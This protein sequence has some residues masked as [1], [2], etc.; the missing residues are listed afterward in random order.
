[1]IVIIAEAKKEIAQL[2]A[3]LNAVQELPKTADLDKLNAN[4]TVYKVQKTPKKLERVDNIQGTEV[5]TKVEL[6]DSDPF[7]HWDLIK[8]RLDAGM[9]PIDIRQDLKELGI[10]IS[11]AE[12]R[13][14]MQKAGMEK[15]TLT[16]L[17][18]GPAIKVAPAEVAP[19]IIPEP[20]KTAETTP[21]VENIHSYR[22][23]LDTK[24]NT[25]YPTVSP[26]TTKTPSEAEVDAQLQQI[27]SDST[28]AEVDAQLW[29]LYKTNYKLNEIVEKMNSQ[30]YQIRKETVKARLLAQGAV[31]SLL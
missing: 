3:W 1:M 2:L 12:I 21:A 6:V 22:M 19:A 15:R 27:T 18:K 9:H 28:R 7:V 25:V 26:I 16:F 17:E 30:G 13:A 29:L 5:K 31:E 10:K 14:L 11:V 4:I 24:G 8:T 20:A 23:P